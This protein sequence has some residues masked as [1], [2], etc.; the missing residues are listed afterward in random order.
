MA[1]EPWQELLFTSPAEAGEAVLPTD[2]AL[3]NDVADLQPAWNGSPAPPPRPRGRGRR[4]AAEPAGPARATPAPSS[5]LRELL[6]DPTPAPAWR[7]TFAEYVELVV[8]DPRLARLSHARIADMIEGEG[9]VQV[10]ADGSGRA[11]P[12]RRYA[13]FADE[14]F[15]QDEVLE[16]VV[17]YFRSAGQGLDIRR[18]IL[19]L[20]GPPGTAKST[21]LILLKRGLERYSRTAAGALY[22]IADCPLHEEPLHLL[23]P[24][25]RD[26][27]WAN[28]GIR[29][30]GELCPV[31]EWRR[32]HE[33]TDIASVPVE[34]VFLSE[35]RRV[36]L[37]T[38]T[39]GD[40]KVVSLE[41][42]VGSLDLVKVA[43]Y[44]SEAHPLAYDFRGAAEVSSRGILELVEVLKLQPELMYPLLT[45]AQEQQIKAGRFALFYAD[46]A[47]I[48]H[49]NEAE[50]R[51]FAAEKKNEAIQSRMF[52]I[53]VPYVLRVADE[54]RIYEKMLRSSSSQAHIAPHTLRVAATWAILSRLAKHPKYPP[55]AK[56]KMYNGE[57]T[58]EHTAREVEDVREEGRRADEGM[59]GIGPRQV[60]NCL[61]NAIAKKDVPC[62]NPIDA[63]RALRESVEHHIGEVRREDADEWLKL[64][65]AEYREIATQEVQR[66][67]IEEFDAAAQT[68]L[69]NY[70]DNAQ[71]YLNDDRVRDPVTGED[72]P[73]DERLMRQIEE[74]IAVAEPAK[75]EFRREILM[76][77]G[78]L[79]RKGETFRWDSHPRL[80]EAIEKKLF[81]DLSG[82]MKVTITTRTPDR[83][84]QER[85]AGVKRKLVER[86][87]YCPHCADA[88]LQF[89][90]HMLQR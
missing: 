26:R 2:P 45:M 32:E 81:G 20:M 69:M 23:G 6:A 67:F 25:A 55:L 64:A 13:F 10:P 41:D 39:P 54:V 89:V 16:Q 85:I 84:Q 35:A 19:L 24:E 18:R 8:A 30:E 77:V 65:S 17:D 82:T 58:A 59:S 60:I 51:R 5:V 71:A 15:G 4:E 50:Y 9:V 21:L 47:I 66:A 68:L 28:H 75:K 83:E 86:Y 42:L 70:L 3:G 27:L 63:I 48:G 37:G 11:A 73:P 44:G 33:W 12:R 61:A 31:C 46:L 29:V 7:G 88:V 76:R 74:A 56:L 87:G 1:I 36:G 52:V 22:G 40:P 38:F 14:I 78:V 79:A 53:K 62:L 57:D 34:R 72:L 90:G 43:Q 80:K 49:S